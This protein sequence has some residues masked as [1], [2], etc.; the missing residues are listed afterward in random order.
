[1]SKSSDVPLADACSDSSALLINSGALCVVAP[2][3]LVEACFSVPA[4]RALKHAR[5]QI[6]L[7]VL[8]EQSQSPLWD[9]L[10]QVDKVIT[11]PEK[12][13]SRQIAKILSDFDMTFESSIVWENCESAKALARAEVIQRFGYPAAG[14]E[15]HLTDP[16]S[17]VVTPSPV[18]H[19]VRHYL[20]FIQELGVEA[21]KKENFSTALLAPAPEKLRIAIAPASA[22]GASYQWPLDRYQ[23]VVDNM[24]S[25]YG[26]IEW[27]ILGDGTLKSCQQICADLAEMLDQ[28]VDNYASQWSMR[29]ILT[30]LPHCSALLACDSHTA[31]LAAHVGLP[32][33]VMFGPNEPNWMRPLGKQSRVIREHVACSP[34]Y[35]P[36]CPLDM[37]CQHQ[38]S[39]GQVSADLEK[40]LAIR[41][42]G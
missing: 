40:V 30:A 37:R 8:C 26:E 15:K 13:S 27:V 3:D 19:R 24:K 28:S 35:Q 23:E 7:V 39:P 11:F 12:S 22:M 33:T 25:R 5:P 32:A 16:V 6:T 31:H 10:V 1:M 38:I 29:E 18:E 34:C 36:K 4:V 41:Y 20:N 21:Y 17:V 2:L 9:T 14:L 42:S